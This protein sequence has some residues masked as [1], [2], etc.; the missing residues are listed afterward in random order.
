M[1]T[2]KH[3]LIIED[4]KNQQFDYAELFEH[5][6]Y[7]PHIAFGKVN[8]I[9]IMLRYMP[10]AV[11]I[12]MSD[13]EEGI[14]LLQH[15]SRNPQIS[16]IPSFFLLSELDYTTFRMVMN[17]GAEDVFLKNEV[18]ESIAE[19]ISNRIKKQ[20]RIIQ[21]TKKNLK[22]EF[23]GEKET[24]NNQDHVLV[25]IRNKLELVKFDDISCIMAEKEYSKIKTRNNKKIIIRKSLRSWLELLPENQFLRIH[26]STII[27]I[28]EIEKIEKI[29]TR[30]Y[31]VY[32]KNCSE[33]FELSQRYTN[34][35]RKT[36]PM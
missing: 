17:A 3:I 30:T 24:K 21:K 1:N 28:E 36:F 35:M 20:N 25:K 15:I 4:N 22:E 29:K 34:I 13:D 33:P 19:A 23:D 10:D 16:T 27:N 32:L 11:I 18:S 9:E 6:E 26:R 8:G 12:D 7:E 14:A 5:T 2:S 31:V